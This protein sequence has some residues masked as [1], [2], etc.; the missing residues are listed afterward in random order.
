[1]ED[2]DH[3][4]NDLYSKA[5]PESEV[6][7]VPL[8]TFANDVKTVSTFYFCSC[9][10]EDFF[11]ICEACAKTCHKDHNPSLNIQG[12]YT[13]KCGESNHEITPAN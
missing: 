3:G 6:I 2:Y 7:K 4:H 5:K 8:C 10:K 13:C 12:I 11:P 9:S 1:M